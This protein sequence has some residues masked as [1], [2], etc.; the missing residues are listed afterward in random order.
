MASSRKPLPMAQKLQAASSEG[1][2][3]RGARAAARACS[4]ASKRSFSAPKKR[5]AAISSS[6]TPSPAAS[7]VKGL[8]GFDRRKP[9]RLVDLVLPAA[10][11]EGARPAREG[12]RAAAGSQRPRRRRPLRATGRPSQ[13][14]S[15]TSAGRQAIA[16]GEGKPGDGALDGTLAR[17]E[18][19]GECRQPEQR[20]HDEPRRGRRAVK[21]WMRESASL[22]M[23]RCARAVEKCNRASRLAQ[24]GWASSTMRLRRSMSRIF[25]SR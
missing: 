12:R 11:Q 13:A 1:H 24:R 10:R 9:Q 25:T 3:Q 4:G 21:R 15:M 20:A 2:Q 19:G 16:H 14:H 17:D 6:A 8:H 23:R 22:L 7:S 18:A 5:P